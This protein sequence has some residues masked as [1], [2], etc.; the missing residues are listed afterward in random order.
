ME[1]EQFLHDVSRQLTAAAALG[2][3][4]TREVAAAL[5]DTARSSVRMAILDALAAAT[6]E[7][8]DALH[9]ASG[10]AQPI[11]AVNLQLT[12]DQVRFTVITPPD[13]EPAE[14]AASRSD[15]GDATA[16]ISLR[17]TDTLKADIERAAGK[18]GVSVN[19]W[20]VRAATRA[21]RPDGAPAGGW[22]SAGGGHRFTGW[23]TG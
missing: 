6:V 3:E 15:D 23:V 2:D 18:A 13:P 9:A 16:R 14:P 17:L 8:T 4:R 21:L 11:P 20:L 19:S 10:G 5:A 7:V 22:R 1:L 12:G